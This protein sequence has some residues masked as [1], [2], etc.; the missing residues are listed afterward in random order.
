M[1]INKDNILN[2]FKNQLS[3]YLIHNLVNGSQYVGNTKNFKRR[4]YKYYSPG[5]LMENRYISRFILKYGHE[6]FS[7]VIMEIII[8]NKDNFKKIILE[9]EQ[10]Y[11]DTLKP[12]LNIN[13]IAESNLEY[14][15]TE[16]TKVIV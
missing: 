4:L 12:T 10:Y 3:V 2:D 15:Y 6:N 11:I 9:R 14:K 5:Y 1:L 13:L 7:V 16:E 8:I